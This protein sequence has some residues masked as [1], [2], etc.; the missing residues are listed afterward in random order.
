MIVLNK[1]TAL[2]IVLISLLFLSQNTN[3]DFGTLFTTASERAIINNNRYVV[4]KVTQ[5]PKTV[6]VA[7][8]EVE[9]PQEIIYKTITNQYKISGISIANNGEDTTWINNKLHENGDVLDKKIKI[10]INSA[11]RK[12]RFTVKGGKTYYGQSGDTVTINYRVPLLD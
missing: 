2:K 7:K 4:K 12:V 3:A 9:E 1:Q 6:S 10:S 5:T 8:I 11:K